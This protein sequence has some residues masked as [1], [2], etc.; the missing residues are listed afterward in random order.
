MA[1]RLADGPAIEVA[2]CVPASTLRTW[3]ARGKLTDHGHDRRGRALYDL[4]EV[5]L[6]LGRS[7]R[8]DEG[9]RLGGCL[10][11]GCVLP[12]VPQAPVTLCVPHL[13]ACVVYGVRAGLVAAGATL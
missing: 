8:T 10:S 12:G 6:E 11:P 1:L 3:R 13:T 4:A 2:Y 7:P 9:N 5:E